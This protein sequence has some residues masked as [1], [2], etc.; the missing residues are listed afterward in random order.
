MA[1]TRWSM[2]QANNNTSNPVATDDPAQTLNGV[3]NYLSA[4]GG[5][6]S[7]KTWFSTAINQLAAWATLVSNGLTAADVAGATINGVDATATYATSVNNTLLLIKNKINNGGNTPNDLVNKAVFAK[8]YFVDSTGTYTIDS[9]VTGTITAT[10]AGGS[11]AVAVA[12]TAGDVTASAKT[13]ADAINANGFTGIRVRAYAQAGVVTLRALGLNRATLTISTGAGTIGAYINNILVTVTATGVDATDA[14][15][16]VTAINSHPTLNKQVFASNASGVVTVQALDGV[17]L[18][19]YGTGMTTVGPRATLASGS[20]SVGIYINGK[21]AS[22]T[23]GTSDAATATALALAINNDGE[24]NQQFFA[25]NPASGV[26]YIT[27][28]VTGDQMV[29]VGG[30]GTGLTVGG[31]TTPLTTLTLSSSSG[32]LYCYINGVPIEYVTVTGASDT[33][34][35][36]GLCLAIN[37]SPYARQFVKATSAAGVVTVIPNSATSLVAVGTGVTASAAYLTASGTYGGLA[38]DAI[39]TT[40]SGTGLTAD[41]ATLS[42]SVSG[43][44]VEASQPGVQGNW[45]TFAAGG[46]AASHVTASSA[47][48]VNGAETLQTCAFG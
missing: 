2:R 4:Q 42:G 5:G 46:A 37:N 35:A 28:R 20:G 22:V 47:R 21:L 24:F 27:S 39:T 26:V 1:T 48:L 9:S 33:A 23:W 19:P 29:A 17:T 8:R 31:T 14:A 38:G 32:T 13:L 41:Q 40:A 10:I 3:K 18:A 16:L 30:R 45:I 15:A 12:S 34:D 44:L 25:L 36:T 43:L 7:G 6:S 11:G